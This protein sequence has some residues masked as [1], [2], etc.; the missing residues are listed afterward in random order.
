VKWVYQILNR[1]PLLRRLT[2]ILAAF[3]QVASIFLFV[4]DYEVAGVTCLITGFVLSALQIPISKNYKELFYGLLFTLA[5]IPLYFLLMTAPFI[6][7]E[8]V[9]SKPESSKVSQHLY[10]LVSTVG[11]LVLALIFLFYPLFLGTS[12]LKLI[13]IK[14][15]KKKAP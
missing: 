9:I 7:F 15:R 10:T 11:V 12:L 13:L 14:V 4:Y 1:Q 8:L 6:L 5:P 2:I 3:A